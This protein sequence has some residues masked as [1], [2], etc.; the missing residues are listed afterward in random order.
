MRISDWSSDVCSSDL[1]FDQAI[2]ARPVEIGQELPDHRSGVGHVGDGVGLARGDRIDRA[3][4]VAIK[5]GLAAGGDVA[6]VHTVS[7]R[8]TGVEA[9]QAQIGRAHV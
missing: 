5:L 9:A 4:Q 1:A 2:E 6:M 8:S 7:Y 3:E